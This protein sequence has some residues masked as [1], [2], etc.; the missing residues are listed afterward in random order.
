M[1][2]ITYGLNFFAI[3]PR[4]E[5]SQR[6][7]PHA[8]IHYCTVNSSIALLQPNHW[9]LLIEYIM[10]FRRQTSEML[11]SDIRRHEYVDR[12]NRYQ[13]L[14]DNWERSRLNFYELFG[15]FFM[16][17]N[18]YINRLRPDSNFFLQ[19]VKVSL[20]FWTTADLLVTSC[21][22]RKNLWNR[23]VNVKVI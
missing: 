7:Y 10:I 9:I 13:L 23:M 20:S 8:K 17:R 22:E 5:F 11:E 12:I 15:I 21:R 18:T 14:L 3:S 2:N 6:I 1:Q 4:Q 19:Q 16:F